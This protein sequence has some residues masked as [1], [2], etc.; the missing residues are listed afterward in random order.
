MRKFYFVFALMFML[1]NVTQ[2]KAEAGDYTVDF[3]GLTA[4]PEGWEAVETTVGFSYGAG[5]YEI[6]SDYAR[7]GK[8][9][10]TYQTSYAGYIVTAP[11]TGDISFYVRARA[12]RK[13]C[14]VKV[15]KYDD[16]VGE[17]ITAAARSY[18]SSNTSTSWQQVT[19]TLEEGTRLA[20][21]LC[22][23]AIDDF[24]GEAY[25]ASEEAEL[26]VTDFASGDTFDFGHVAAGTT[27]TFTLNN[28]GLSELE[29]TSVSVTG[30]YTITDGAEPMTIAAQSSATVTVATPAADATGALTI[31]SNDA[32][33]PYVISLTS[34]YK[35]PAPIMGLD[36]TTV[37]FG[38]VTAD[39]EQVITVSNTGDA[40]LT[41]T[42]ASD[43][44]D[45]TVAPASLTVAAGETATFT[46]TYVYDAEAYGPHAA[47]VT[48]T[49]NAGEAQTI[50]VTAI[51]Q[52]PNVWTENFE[53][54]ALPEGW[55]ADNNWSFSDGVAHGKYAYGSTKYY[56]T[57]PAL[58]V[59]AG[60]ELTFNYKRSYDKMIIEYQK[61]G[62]AWTQ[63]YADPS[64]VSDSDWQTYTI[65][66]L[67]A[68]SYRFRFV[69]GDYD[70]DNFEGFKLNLNAPV[71][72]VT[73]AEA[74]DFGKVTASASKT[75]TVA[76]TGTGEMT[77]NITSDKSE[78]TVE[79]A[80]L[81]V[82][83]EPQT[84]TVTFN[85]TEGN[86]GNFGATI[87]VTPTYSESAAVTIEASATA[88]DP[89]VWEEEFADGTLPTGWEANGWTVGTFKNY[90]NTTPMA[91]APASSTSGTLITPALEAKAGDVLN[92][93]AYLNWYDEALI[94]EYSSDEKATWTEIY[95]YETRNDSE[96]PSTSQRYYN[97]PMSFTAPADGVYYLRFT[98]TYQN[99]VDN[100][101][102]FKLVV[103]DH[104]IAVS[105][106]VIPV[107]FNQYVETEV[108]VTLK[109][110]AGK[111]ETVSVMFAVGE[112]GYGSEE[113]QLAA[114]EEKTVTIP[115]TFE[116]A[117]VTGPASFLMQILE[118]GP[119]FNSDEVEISVVPAPTLD[120]TVGT[121]DGFT[122]FGSYP[123]VVLK[124]NMKA[125]WNTLVLP[126]AVSDLTIF[127][128]N[129]KA[130][131][132]TGYTNGE[133][134]FA[135]V[136]E[137][138][139][140][141]PYLIQADEAQTEFLFKDVTSFRTSTEAADLNISKDGVLFQGTYAPMEAGTMAGKYG[142]VP[143]GDFKKG[144]AKA[145]MK[146]FRAYFELPTDAGAVS[147]NILEEDGSVT[148]ISGVELNE[149]VTGDVYDLSGRKMNATT[150]KPG[151]YVKNGKKV[152]V[153]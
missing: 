60:D 30:N 122:N 16:G 20:F 111:D 137:L 17:E 131:A 49:P 11:V 86:Y 121:L 124:Y 76:N 29:I 12:T 129:A 145:T 66:G 91:L 56:L 87:T 9:L 85:Y 95:N 31:V 63:L 102:G 90:A 75:Y 36:M 28:R 45:F 27:K 88:K 34:T 119:S 10:F 74:A 96:A 32:N 138:T 94:V 99:G 103:K 42:I 132:F 150:L 52:D 43:N 79:P 136:T 38:K 13:A 5:T 84:F 19:F 4:L 21:Q 135:P 146:G 151:I 53:G 26:K 15:F 51:V 54:N 61:D 58:S 130:Y 92:W 41:A 39:A 2:M 83:D 120:E 134:N 117:G 71:M 125:G 80:T 77:V 22:N 100:F 6:S 97:K 106:Y 81:T 128:E 142:V 113:I 148:R 65:S 82:S 57:T 116:D 78:F 153:K 62:G 98:S 33:S 7:S 123:V 64:Y 147:V 70:L 114:G 101:N 69:N 118:D 47:T 89:N 25:V 133:L 24:V 37:A 55:E 68:G 104:D 48:V 139:A 107:N 112:I 1:M 8:G 44:A 140:Q 46:V 18:T 144:S 93:D 35:A 141:Q 127:G 152:I 59:V 108:S 143:A 40:E 3:N 50:A 149:T 23:A 115:V 109:E 72:E 73:P 105:S 110:L 14:G 126:F 67:E